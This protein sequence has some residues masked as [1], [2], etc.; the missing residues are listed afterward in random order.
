MS[1]AKGAARA[2]GAP[3]VES[4]AEVTRRTAAHRLKRGLGKC[5]PIFLVLAS[6]FGEVAK[7]S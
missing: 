6:H 1:L 2:R 7:T 4:T 3:T 5:S